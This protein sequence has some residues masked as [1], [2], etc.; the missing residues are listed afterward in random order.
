MKKTITLEV[1]NKTKK[2]VKES[3]QIQTYVCRSSLKKQESQAGR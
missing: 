2:D 3:V 1:K